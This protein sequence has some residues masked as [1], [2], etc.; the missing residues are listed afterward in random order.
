MP[1]SHLLL[2]TLGV[3]LHCNQK[4]DCCCTYRH[5]WVRFDLAMHV[6]IIL[7]IAVKTYP[8]SLRAKFF[9]CIQVFRPLKIEIGTSWNFLKYLSRSGV[10]LKSTGVRSLTYLGT[11]EKSTRCQSEP[12]GAYI[13]LKICP[14][15]VVE[16]C[17]L[18]ILTAWISFENGTCA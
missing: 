5:T 14:L 7:L 1:K 3:H 9:Q 2:M 11:V 10:P 6:A 18:I 13:P 12:S 17:T 15:S 4:H 8:K 16:N